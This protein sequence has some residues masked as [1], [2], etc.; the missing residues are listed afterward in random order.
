MTPQLS[1]STR[2]RGITPNTHER[3]GSHET[4]RRRDI[5]I[6]AW[7]GEQY[8]ARVDQLETL[9]D[10]G[11]RTVQRVIARLRDAGLVT[12]RRLLVGEPAW[13]LP[14]SAG[15]RAAGAGFGAWQPRIGL[16]AHVAAVNDV[17]LHVRA[18]SPESEWV[19]ERL[20]ARER[21]A[22]EHLPDG[23]VLTEGR[24]VAIEVELTVKSQR[25]VT[26]I[27]DEL[28]RRFDAVLYFCAPGPHRQLTQLAETGRWGKLGVRELPGPPPGA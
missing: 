27:L 16:L 3:R 26:T 2:W 6:L 17:R 8:A 18:L 11:P 20:L 5:E 14:T 21:K 13:V 24:R 4:L 28:S 22:G 10:C 25:R 23:V 19:P 15:L 12:T 7:L 1:V 9:L